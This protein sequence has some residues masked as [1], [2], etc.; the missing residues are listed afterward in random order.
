[1]SSHI[2]GH[3]TSESPTLQEKIM[4]EIEIST[5]FH[6][7]PNEESNTI[8]KGIQKGRPNVQCTYIHNVKNVTNLQCKNRT[9]IIN[10]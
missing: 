7:N 5:P 1:M 3:A 6:V 2:L 9:K 10:L 4:D 8:P